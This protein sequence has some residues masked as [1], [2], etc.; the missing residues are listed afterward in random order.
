MAE[1]TA[2][3]RTR[4]VNKVARAVVGLSLDDIKKKASVKPDVRSAQRDAA[5]KEVKARK[6]AGKDKKT[7]AKGRGTGAG[8]RTKLPKNVRR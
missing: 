6:A 3:K 2:K 8:Q 4:R 1:T 7:S 5:I